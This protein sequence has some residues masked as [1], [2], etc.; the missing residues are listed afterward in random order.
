MGIFSSFLDKFKSIRLNDKN[1]VTGKQLDYLLVGSM[2]AEQQSAYLNSYE[3]GL[4]KTTLKK[5]LED[6]WQIYDRNEAISTL[7]DLQ[8]RNQD[9]YIDVL[10]TA[11]ENSENYV[12]VL[13][14]NL[15]AEE[16][17]FKYYLEIYRNK[18]GYT[19]AYRTG[20]DPEF[21]RD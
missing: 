16:E 4:N 7:S 12:A 14:S 1:E 10:Y 15:P 19:G 11:F 13:K 5:I 18:P 3:T 8:D 6:Y 17:R 21:G 20:R 2:Y 9:K